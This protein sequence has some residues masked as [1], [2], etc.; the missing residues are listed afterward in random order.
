MYHL[1]VLPDIQSGIW[2]PGE[3]VDQADITS[4]AQQQRAFLA[5]AARPK[6]YKQ[7]KIKQRRAWQAREGSRTSVAGLANKHDARISIQGTLDI[8]YGFN[9]VKSTQALL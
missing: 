6:T 8:H 1:S 4:W 9:L 7:Q 2:H 5:Q 3:F